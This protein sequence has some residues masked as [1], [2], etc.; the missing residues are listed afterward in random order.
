MGKETPALSACSDLFAERRMVAQSRFN[1]G[2]T[3]SLLLVAGIGSLSRRGCLLLLAT[4]VVA[5]THRVGDGPRRMRYDHASDSRS[6]RPADRGAADL[7]DGPG[8]RIAHLMP[9]AGLTPLPIVL[10]GLRLR[11]APRLILRLILRLLLLLLLGRSGLRNR[12]R[13]AESRGRDR[14]Q[15]PSGFARADHPL[16]PD[17]AMVFGCNKSDRARLFQAKSQVAARRPLQRV[18]FRSRLSGALPPLA[19][20]IG[21]RIPSGDSLIDRS[22]PGKTSCWSAPARARALSP[23]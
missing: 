2:E 8:D 9:D 3:H 7:A 6:D 15:H 23:P 18:G 5:T 22:G 14:E 1:L 16:F 10:L 19:P 12:Y 13:L 11:G 20:D 17:L 4:V 21:A